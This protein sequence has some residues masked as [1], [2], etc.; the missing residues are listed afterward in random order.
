M[1]ER[2][3]SIQF[4]NGSL[5]LI[6]YTHEHNIIISQIFTRHFWPFVTFEPPCLTKYAKNVLSTS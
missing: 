5:N 6:Y 4:S 1:W 3:Y 2:S